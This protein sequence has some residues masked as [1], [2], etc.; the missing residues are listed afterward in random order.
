MTRAA[1]VWGGAAA[2]ILGLGA[3]SFGIVVTQT[4][5]AEAHVVRYLDALAGGNL[6]SAARLAGLE[7]PTTMPLGDEAAP[8]IR[9]IIGVTANSD[10]TVTVLAEYGDEPDAGRVSFV[11]KP[12]PPVLGFFP[13]W[14]FTE[15]PL[16]VLE[17]GADH[18]DRVTV[19]ERVV[20][21]GGAGQTAAVSVFVPAQ[22]T[23]RL[24]EPLL[25]ADPVSVR[26]TSA[27]LAP[28]LLRA[29][30]TAQ[31]ERI[32]QQQLDRFISECVTQQVLLPT[33]C[34]FGVDIVD[35]V[36]DRPQWQLAR[37]PVIAL[38]TGAQPGVW[39]VSG[40]AEVRLRVTVQQLFDGIL[41]DRDELV[42]VNLNG[43]VVLQPEGPV[44]TVFLPAG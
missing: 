3:L 20:T 21:T 41:I 22:V 23:V 17:V 33:G 9:R 28:V 16:A 10:E 12:A 25:R 37:A 11:L 15:P 13:A 5:S 2:A 7:A 6:A 44:L 30:P 27:A 19:G 35:R 1:L 38:A 34:P 36:I 8:G 31:F 4:T 29:E 40:T 14:A 24:N 43:N 39:V 42:P 18:H 32:V 26:M